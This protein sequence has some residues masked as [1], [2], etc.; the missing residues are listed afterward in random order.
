MALITQGMVRALWRDLYRGTG[1]DKADMKGGDLPDPT[2][3]RAI[4]QAIEDRWDG[5]KMNYKAAMDAAAG[6]TLTNAQAKVFGKYWL[7]AKAQRGN[8]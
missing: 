8:V 6:F 1:T 3:I 5:D 7:K 2:Q 4:F